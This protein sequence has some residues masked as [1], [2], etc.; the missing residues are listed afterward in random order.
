MRYVVLLA[1]VAMLA[2][3]GAGLARTK[4]HVRHVVPGYGAQLGSVPDQRS[5]LAI[6]HELDPCHCDFGGP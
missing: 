4:H 5:W 6:E 3:T 1:A 2:S